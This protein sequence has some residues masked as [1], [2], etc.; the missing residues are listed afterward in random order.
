MEKN[1]YLFIYVGAQSFQF[2]SL[3]F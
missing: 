1:I 3:L 2:P